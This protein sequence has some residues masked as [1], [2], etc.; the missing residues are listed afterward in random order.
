MSASSK[1]YQLEEDR[2]DQS[3]IEEISA[4]GMLDP[5]QCPERGSLPSNAVAASPLSESHLGSSSEEGQGSFPLLALP[6]TTSLGSDVLDDKVAELMEF[7]SLKYLLKEPTTRAEMQMIVTKDYEEHFPVIFGEASKCMQLVFG[8]D[9]E[10]VGPNSHFYVLTPSLGLTYDGMV[11]DEQNHPRTIVLIII[12][13]VI[14]IQGNRAREEAIWEVLSGMGLYPGSEHCIYG[15]P[16][17]FLTE[18]LVQEQYVACV[19]VP[20]SDP[21]QYEFLWGPRAH[22]ETSVE[23]VLEFL[24]KL[25]DS[26]LR[27]LPDCQEEC[28]EDEEGV[29]ELVPK[30]E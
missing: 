10:E 22:A 5:P 15:E 24:G 14:F 19:E 4:A 3:T 26:K 12:L 6:E 11:N 21:P 25:K 1:P 23:E 20:N 13:S 8:I 18:D 7:L 27:I 30:E 2:E 29:P 17:K 28:S 9:I 16:R